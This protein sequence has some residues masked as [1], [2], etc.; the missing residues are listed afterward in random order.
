MSN[1]GWPSAITA[2]YR[3]LAKSYGANNEELGLPGTCTTRGDDCLR[4]GGLLDN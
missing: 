2:C 4:A 3:P 1:A